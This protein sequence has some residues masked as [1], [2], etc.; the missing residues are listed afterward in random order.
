MTEAR[1]DIRFAGLGGQGVVTAGA[2]L[3]SAAAAEG[4]VASGSTTYGSQ[5][6]GG[7]AYADVALS[8]SSIDFPHLEGADVLVALSQQAYDEYRV[9]VKP[10][11]RILYDPFHVKPRDLPGVRQHEV[12]ATRAAMDRLGSGQAA[13][14]V[15]LGALASL[16]ELLPAEALRTAIRKEGSP[17]FVE[18]NLQALEIGLGLGQ[19][20]RKD[21][22]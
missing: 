13:N 15:M 4:W 5:A 12:A 6:R 21:A 18:S 7:S 14:I 8:R 3:G 10:T 11:G 9:L 22:P 20:L 16:S 2:L 17:R 1:I 19:A